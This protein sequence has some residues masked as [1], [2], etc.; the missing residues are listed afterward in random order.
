MIVRYE[1]SMARHIILKVEYEG[2]RK[3]NN[4]EV[5]YEKSKKNVDCT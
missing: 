5:E 2:E 4:L 3:E 1:N